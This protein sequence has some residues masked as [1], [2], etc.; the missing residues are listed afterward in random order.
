M[1]DNIS[2]KQNAGTKT[3]E[4]DSKK[5]PLYPDIVENNDTPLHAWSVW[6]ECQSAH[7]YLCSLGS[8]G[9]HTHWRI[10]WIA[11]LSLL[12]TIRYV[13]QSVDQKKSSWH[14]RV[15]DDFLKEI[16]KNKKHHPIYWKFVCNERD[17]LIHE[18]STEVRP[19]PVTTSGYA[20]RG[21]SY[22]QLVAKYGEHK[23]IVWGDE[24]EDG[25][26]LVE[27]A[28]DWWEMN[29]RVIEQAIREHERFPFSTNY[30]RWHELVES[31]FKYRQRPS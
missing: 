2:K 31:S 18:F 24:A 4:S 16:G 7:S 28:L 3:T 5:T 9:E 1:K 20:D 30:K 10:Y 29:L 11:C 22:D 8:P 6:H 17:N 23:I 12:K 13:L 14:S 25:L 15:V 21:L 26:E 19:Y 27:K